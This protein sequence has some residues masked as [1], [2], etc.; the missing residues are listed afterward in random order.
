MHEASVKPCLTVGAAD[1]C[2]RSGNREYPAQGA[3]IVRRDGAIEGIPGNVTDRLRNML[4]YLNVIDAI[5]ELKVPPN[6]G[7]H[8][9]GGDRTGVWALTVTRNWRLTFRVGAN[10]A[11]E[12]IDLEDYH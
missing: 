11:I 7:A 2:W 3:A 12:D 4:A 5:D 9:L 10:G 8:L 6:Y 1:I